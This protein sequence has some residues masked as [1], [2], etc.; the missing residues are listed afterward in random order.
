MLLCKMVKF[1]ISNRWKWWHRGPHSTQEWCSGGRIK[2]QSQMKTNVKREVEGRWLQR[3]RGHPLL[4]HLCRHYTDTQ[5][6]AEGVKRMDHA[7]TRGRTLHR[8]RCR[9]ETHSSRRRVCMSRVV[10]LKKKRNSFELVVNDDL[11][12]LIGG[13]EYKEQSRELPVYNRGWWSRCRG[14]LI[15][16]EAHRLQPWRALRPLVH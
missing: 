6:T 15:L 1:S 4:L 5:Q 2:P 10:D 16:L 13:F 14:L 7:S 3:G 11:E 8:R 12:R 9:D